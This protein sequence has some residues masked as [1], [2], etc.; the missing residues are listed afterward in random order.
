VPG[1]MPIH[2]FPQIKRFSDRC[3]AG[4]PGWL[5]RLFDGIEPGSD[6]HKMVAASVAGEQSRRLVAEGFDHLHI[7]ALN[8]AEL[9]VAVFR[10]L[11]GRPAMRLAA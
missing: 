3:G 1:I 9:S 2:S 10:L 4:M 8:R 7:Y 6:L 5:V 11:G